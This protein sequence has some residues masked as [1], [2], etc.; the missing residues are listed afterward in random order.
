MTPQE[1]T[2]KINNSSGKELF[3]YTRWAYKENKREFLNVCYQR[4]KLLNA[5]F[6]GDW[7][8]AKKQFDTMVFPTVKLDQKIFHQVTRVLGYLCEFNQEMT[9]TMQI[10]NKSMV[11]YNHR[12]N[13]CSVR[14]L[15]ANGEVSFS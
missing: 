14:Q 5:H 1:L 7:E 6:V 10:K 3:K 15:I 8:E 9:D 2:V 4:A 13:S 11:L 12:K